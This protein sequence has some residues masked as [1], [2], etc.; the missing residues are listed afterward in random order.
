LAAVVVVFG[1]R[2]VRIVRSKGERVVVVGLVASVGAGLIFCSQ[3]RKEREKQLNLNGLKRDDFEFYERI[4][5]KPIKPLPREK[6][7]DRF[8]SIFKDCKV[9]KWSKGLDD[10][11]KYFTDNGENNGEN[12]GVAN[13]QNKLYLPG[14]NQIIPKL[15]KQDK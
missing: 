10:S 2:I 8:E 11:I 6:S 13:N 14:T 5:D 9:E 4:S 15:K 7:R 12:N 3:S 1:K